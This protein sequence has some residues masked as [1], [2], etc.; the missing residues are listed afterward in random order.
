MLRAGII[1]CGGITERRH[2]PVLSSLKGRVELAALSDVSEAR[3]AFI[4]DQYGVPPDHRYTDYETMLQSES[5]DLV[6]ICT[7]HHLHEPQAVAALQAG[8]HVLMEKP[9]ATSVEEANRIISAADYAGKKLTISHNQLF[10]PL[11]QAVM[12][13]LQQGDIGEVFLVR[14]EGLS[15]HHVVGRGD[16]QH[17][18]ASVAS[19][20]GG[21][22]ID[23]GYHQIYCALKYVQSPAVRVYARIGRYVRDIDTEDL[24]M[25]FIE[26]DNGATTSLQVGWCATTGG[27]HVEEIFGKGGQI[28]LG[29]PYPLSVWQEG[30]E[31]WSETKVGAEGH[32][33]VGFPPLA[34]AFITAIEDDSP[35]P[36]PPEASRD[37]LAI[38]RAAYESGETGQP[39]NI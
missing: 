31:A 29:S 1:G 10:R 39:V 37:V 14:T 7:P 25:L 36:V 4:G 15:K 12:N 5:L 6:H 23:N 16:G 24:A 9:I 30:A 26:H 32:D 21:P 27:I 33:E 35:V 3:L 38:V 17:W 19:G 18:R 8:A 2:A 22:L 13:H 34:E 20:G 11:H 28:R